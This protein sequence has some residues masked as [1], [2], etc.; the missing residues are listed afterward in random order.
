[1]VQVKKENSK[2]AALTCCNLTR[3]DLTGNINPYITYHHHFIYVFLHYFTLIY[4]WVLIGL[5]DIYLTHKHTLAS[6]TVV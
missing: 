6:T 4:L 5:A 3:Y 2:Q 1:M